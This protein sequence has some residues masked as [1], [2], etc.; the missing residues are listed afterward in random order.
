MKPRIMLLGALLWLCALPTLRAQDTITFSS[1]ED[2]MDTVFGDID[3]S[4]YPS[5][6]L[7]NKAPYDEKM[8]NTYGQLGVEPITVYDWLFYYQNIREATQG[9]YH[10]I[11]GEELYSLGRTS[12]YETSFV[13]LALLNYTA[14]AIKEESFSNGDVTFSNRQLHV[15]TP[16]AMEDKRIF[17][18]VPLSDVL[19]GP[20][21]HFRLS[22]TLIFTN[23]EDSL[24]SIEVDFGDGTGTKTF[25]V[26]DE[27]IVHYDAQ[28]PVQIQMAFVYNGYKLYSNVTAQVVHADA[29]RNLCIFPFQ[30]LLNP[31]VPMTQGPD[32]ISTNIVPLPNGTSVGQ[33]TGEYAIWH[34]CGNG[35]VLRK[36]VIISAGFNPGNGKQLLPCILN[37]GS[38]LLSLSWNGEWR[39]TYF[40]T[41]NGVFNEN[42]SPNSP[43]G[44][45]NGT[46]L[47]Q[48]LR[49]EGYDIII[50]KYDHGTDY[51]QNNASLLIE[52]IKWT[53]QQLQMNGSKHEIVVMGYSIG[54]VST[55]YALAKMEQDYETHK[56]TPSSYLYPPHRC[57][58][59]VSVDGEHQA[60]NVPLGFQHGMDFLHNTPAVD[61][62]D[63]AGKFVAGLTLNIMNTPTSFQLT[64]PH[65]LNSLGSFNPHPDRAQL[66]SDLAALTPGITNPVLAGYP[67]Y[68][69]R[70]GVSQGS[71]V[72]QTTY[73]ISAGQQ[74][75]N[76]HRNIVPILPISYY[77][78]LDCWFTDG[79]PYT[80]L[81]R[82]ER[83]VRF[84]WGAIVVQYIPPYLQ[85]MNFGNEK[86]YDNSPG[87][88]L[89]PIKEFHHKGGGQIYNAGAN[90]TYFNIDK[91]NMFVPTVSGLDLHDPVT[92]Q[93]LYATNTGL[94][95]SV[96]TYNLFKLNSSASHPSQQYGFPFHSY[97][98]NPYQVTPFDAVWAVGS[99]FSGLDRNQYHVEDPPLDMGKYLANVEIAPT[100]LYLSN[101]TI[102][103]YNDAQRVYTAAF[104][105]RNTVTC[106]NDIYGNNSIAVGS[107]SYIHELTPDG[108]FVINSHTDVD[109]RAGN[110]IY[111]KP[112]FEAHFGAE[113]HAFIN[114]YPVSCP[115][116]LKMSVPQITSTHSQ[117]SG[118]TQEPETPVLSTLAV[119][120]NPNSGEFTVQ[121]QSPVSGQVSVDIFDMAGKQVLTFSFQ[122]TEGINYLPLHTTGIGAGIYY[123]RVQGMD[124]IK[125][126][127]ITE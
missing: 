64:N 79:N 71:S 59:W 8:L 62:M 19:V 11:A 58:L 109:M 92:Q 18:C 37:D 118:N 110:E 108:D 120:P 66:L 16:N 125:K 7:I 29:E 117:Q 34:G 20:E 83:G 55:R 97:S 53:N 56:N 54:A 49:E 43:T 5:G 12:S 33:I 81:V 27:V 15:S 1:Y 40:E 61:V 90:D 4:Y 91:N 84:F 31:V 98:G 50:L 6:I 85:N 35:G 87:S 89:S 115:D 38:S 23:D 51:V 101:R 82:R 45:N 65:H 69:R 30:L 57:R 116:N 122:L 47:L 105:A 46:N 76:I 113:F 74:F 75:L 44:D 68:C 80:P 32:P 104:E 93:I 70:V 86:L 114:P 9:Q 48:R 42:M 3:T 94:T 107:N 124:E 24:L 88:M 111:L 99:T 103:D 96:S 106:G 14:Q 112:G 63:I 119:Y 10:P 52:M 67:Q 21:V 102:H 26:N 95:T 73:D 39:G 78:F 127:V 121:L 28:G 100:D 36:P 77:R 126:V 41:Y 25:G 60:S 123:L 13:P 17:A 72:G 22:D 2:A